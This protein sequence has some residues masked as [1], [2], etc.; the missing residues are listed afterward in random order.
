[1][2]LV[3]Y[4]NSNVFELI[5]TEAKMRR[6]QQVIIA[7]FYRNHAAITYLL[8]LFLSLSSAPFEVFFL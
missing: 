7:F 3:L 4:D 8:I 2:V 1:M 6:V 5:F